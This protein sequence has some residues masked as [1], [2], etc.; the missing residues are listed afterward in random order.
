MSRTRLYP[1]PGSLPGVRS[2]SGLSPLARTHRLGQGSRPAARPGCLKEEKWRS[3]HSVAVS[4]CDSLI[5]A[6]RPHPHVEFFFVFGA[7]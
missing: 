7:Q 3:W 5:L 6:W 2:R 4:Q 1:S